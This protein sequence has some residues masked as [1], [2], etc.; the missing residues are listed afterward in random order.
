MNFDDFCAKKNIRYWKLPFYHHLCAVLKVNE[1]GIIAEKYLE[2]EWTKFIME[3][4]KQLS[5]G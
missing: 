4:A 3:T 5:K 2:T 1:L